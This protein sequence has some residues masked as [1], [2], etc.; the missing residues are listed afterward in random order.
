MFVLVKKQTIQ[1]LSK[2][3]LC[4]FYLFHTFPYFPYISISILIFHTHHYF[5]SPMYHL[6]HVCDQLLCNIIFSK[7][8]PRKST[9]QLHSYTA[10]SSR[11]RDP[12]NHYIQ[13]PK[14]YL[15]LSFRKFV[16]FISG[17]MSCFVM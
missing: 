13:G 5:Y 15:S 1:L 8:Q 16:T 7:Y 12:L 3:L 2:S 11:D 6:L 17:K 14:A 4:S 9:S 10:P